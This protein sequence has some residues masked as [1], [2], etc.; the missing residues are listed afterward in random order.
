MKTSDWFPKRKE[1]QIGYSP[2]D[3]GSYRVNDPYGRYFSVRWNPKA[4]N[5]ARRVELASVSPDKYWK[6][7]GGRGSHGE[8]PV[9]VTREYFRKKGFTVLASEP[10]LISPMDAMPEGYV[11]CSYPG[12]RKRGAECYQRM[13]DIFGADVL[14]EL[15]A[16]MDIARKKHGRTT[17]GGDPDLFVYKGDGK[18][19][20]FFVEVKDKD[21]LITNQ[22]ICFPLIEKYLKCEVRVVRL[23]EVS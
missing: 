18:R 11:L 5:E 22:K 3:R 7:L 2:A 20:R 1:I 6:T 17:H 19:V 16:E 23:V 9:V 21:Q 12:Y 14:T 10:R 8:F 4:I 15:N 13:V